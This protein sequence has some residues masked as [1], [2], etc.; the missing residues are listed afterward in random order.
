MINLEKN[1]LEKVPGP[2]FKKTC[3]CTILSPPFLNFSDPPPPVPHHHH[4]TP[5]PLIPP[6]NQEL[7]MNRSNQTLKLE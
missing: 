4:P 1:Q 2:P 3:P 6:I 7:C 5:P